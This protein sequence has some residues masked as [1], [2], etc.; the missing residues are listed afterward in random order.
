MQKDFI[1]AT[2]DSGGS[3]STT[4]TAAASANQT[5]SARSVNLS[6]AG[7]GMTRTVA[8][9]QAAGVV[10]WN[11]YFSVTPTSLSFVAGG[12]SKTVTVT[13]YRKKVINGVET[14]TQKNVAW[15]PTV[16]GTGFSVSGST[17][18]AAANSAT[19][20]RSGTAT[21]T[22]TDS[23]KTQGVSL[24]QAAAAKITVSPT[25][26]FSGMS[27]PNTGQSY[28]T[29][30]TVSNC[31]TKPTVSITMNQR[32]DDGFKHQ[33]GDAENSEPVSAGNNTWTFKVWPANWYHATG[34]TGISLVPGWY[35]QGKVTVTLTIGN[36]AT[37][38]IQGNVPTN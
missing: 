20:T 22:Q 1:T 12:E 31:P 7:G 28:A 4:V 8:A 9:S 3:G 15:T 30:I 24:S 5:E 6:V 21:Y 25:T 26:V 11:Y 18:T 36:S 16:S 37:V 35:C 29:T 17:V 32:L 27:S 23:G 33:M 10:T 34:G 14:S 19:T 2:P 13:S 38:S